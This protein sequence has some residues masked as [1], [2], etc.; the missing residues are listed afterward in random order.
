MITA[1]VSSLDRLCDRA[2]QPVNPQQ[3][4]C[5]RASRAERCDVSS[6]DGVSQC[7]TRSNPSA[8]IS[9]RFYRRTSAIKMPRCLKFV[10]ARSEDGGF[11]EQ[12]LMCCVHEGVSAVGKGQL[13]PHVPELEAVEA[14]LL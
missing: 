1:D 7:W 9:L 11:Y 8:Y 10:G 4:R 13:I 6:I 14:G 2:A 3:L 12:P 5:G